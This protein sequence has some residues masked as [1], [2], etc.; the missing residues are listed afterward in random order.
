[1][2]AV[3]AATKVRVTKTVAAYI[4]IAAVITDAIALSATG[5]RADGNP[6]N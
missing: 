1:M 6:S 4:A 3:T 2:A 5:T